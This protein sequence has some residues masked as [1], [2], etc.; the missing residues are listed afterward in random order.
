MSEPEF[1]D[2]DWNAGLRVHNWRNHVPSEIRALWLTFT[3]PQREALFHWMEDE[4]SAEE[5]E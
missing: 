1:A 4:A 2:P 5:W 3:L